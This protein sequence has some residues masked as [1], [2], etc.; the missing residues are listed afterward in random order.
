VNADYIG[1]GG[2]G[3]GEAGAYQECAGAAGSTNTCWKRARG[4]AEPGVI[5]GRRTGHTDEGGGD[6]RRDADR[7][8]TSNNNSKQTKKDD[9]SCHLKVGFLRAHR[10]RD[11]WFTSRMLS[12]LLFVVLLFFFMGGGSG[13]K[14]LRTRRATLHLCED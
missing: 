2:R 9:R 7:K 6:V 4:A 14:M 5:R 10:S 3:G 1:G 13:G 11:T 8:Q 12:L